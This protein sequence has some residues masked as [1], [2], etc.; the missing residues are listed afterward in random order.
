MA[1]KSYFRK[2]AWRKLLLSFL[3]IDVHMLFPKDKNWCVTIKTQ[4]YSIVVAPAGFEWVS[5]DLKEFT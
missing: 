4:S 1:P 3:Q 5:N 2:A